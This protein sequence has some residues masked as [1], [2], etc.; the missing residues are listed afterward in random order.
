MPP[1]LHAKANPSKRHCEKRESLGRSLTMGRIIAEQRIGAVWLEIHM[2]K[3]S[4][5]NIMAR[6]KVFGLLPNCFWSIA[7]MRSS[8]WHL[9]NADEM[10]YPPSKSIYSKKT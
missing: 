8:S 5:R 6:M 10:E 9:E 4:P 1:K 2:L 7:A 3:K